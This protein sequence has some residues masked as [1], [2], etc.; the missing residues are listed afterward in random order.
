MLAYLNGS[1]ICININN[2]RTC[3]AAIFLSRAQ[4]SGFSGLY[5]RRPE[6][7]DVRGQPVA[8]RAR[9]VYK[10]LDPKSPSV[11]KK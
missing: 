1:K 7:F 4:G 5:K 11:K 6:G 3:Q 2:L 9:T 10:R 8:M